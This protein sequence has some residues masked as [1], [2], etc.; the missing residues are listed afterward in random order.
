MGRLAIIALVLQLQ[1]CAAYTAASIATFAT[2]GKGITD[3][4]TS[5]VTQGDCNIVQPFKGQYYCEMP[6]VYNRSGI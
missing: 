4:T 5:I 3:H 6:V 1:G 2:T